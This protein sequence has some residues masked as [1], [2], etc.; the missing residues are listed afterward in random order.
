MRR[1]LA[2][3]GLALLTLTGCTGTNVGANDDTELPAAETL[4]GA[5]FEQ[6]LSDC[7]AA[8]LTDVLYGWPGGEAGAAE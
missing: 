3:A 8:A 7:R 1:T 5:D 6:V 4:A 2:V